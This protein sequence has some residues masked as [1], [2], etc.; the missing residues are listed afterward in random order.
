MARGFLLTM[1]AGFSSLTKLKAQLLAPSLVNSQNYDLQIQAIGLG[2]TSQFEHFCDRAF[3]WKENDQVI[4]PADRV[5][6]IVP[7]YPIASILAIE[8]LTNLAD[9]WQPL[10]LSVIKNY[11][12]KSGVVYIDCDSDLGDATDQVRI[13]YTGGHWWDTT[14]D[15]TGIKPDQATLIHDD[16]ML[17]WQLQCRHM[18]RMTDRLGAG[19]AQE[20]EKQV[21]DKQIVMMDMVK[22]LLTDHMRLQLI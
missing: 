19:I 6:F 18:W 13:T 9:G 11:T 7:R 20:P 15:G 1:N 14:E 4:L 5:T 3:A 2:V 16:I 8:L 10:D 17:A 12:A 21:S 22:D